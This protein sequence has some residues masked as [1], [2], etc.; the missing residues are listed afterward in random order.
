MDEKDSAAVAAYYLA[1]E[2]INIHSTY[3]EKR[4]REAKRRLEKFNVPLLNQLA[5][6]L[7]DASS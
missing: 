4:I 7:T 6:K 3:A 2:E 5:K 1:R